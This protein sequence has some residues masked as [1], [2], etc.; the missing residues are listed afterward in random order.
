MGWDGEGVLAGRYRRLE[1]I[2]RGGMGSVWRAHDADLDREV[3]VKE[4]RVPEQVG[5]DE[6]AVWFARMEREARAAARL[7]HPGIVTVH[8]RVVGEDGRPWIVMELVQGRSLD[9]V[10]AD[11]GVLPARRVAA[12]GLAM[13]DA[14][15]AAHAQGIVHRD[16]KPANVLLEDERVVLTD[17]GIAAVEGDATLTRSGAVLGT[18][19]Y[20]SPEQVQGG[21][22]TPA[23]DLWSL[24]ATLYA[25]V[26]GR[27][28]FTAPTH[29]ALFVAIATR[30]PDPPGCGGPLGQVLTELLRKVPAERPSPARV[31]EL[32]GAVA[33]R[34]VP[35]VDAGP[36]RPA[37]RFDVPAD[38]TA[39]LDGDDHPVSVRGA[40]VCTWITVA[41]T[42]LLSWNNPSDDFLQG[43]AGY[44]SPVLIGLVIVLSAVVWR[45]THRPV[46]ALAAV[47]LINMGLTTSVLAAT[48]ERSEVDIS[49]E[50]AF[51][52]VA[53]AVALMFAF[54]GANETLLAGG[55]SGA[56]RR[57][58]RGGLLIVEGVVMTMWPWA[59]LG[60]LGIDINLT[61]A[62]IK[63]SYFAL[64]LAAVFLVWIAA[65]FVLRL[66]PRGI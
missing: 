47:A 24:G 55:P 1:L 14:L 53:G 61:N 36:S 9:R 17:F 65:Q 45:S 23:S 12:I 6:R 26:E 35:A 54:A 48:G 39:L 64:A 38:P 62:D 25:A 57:A 4:L 22:V 40:L 29:G 16:V 37:A 27:P 32:L 44:W 15:S 58:L 59:L 8:D 31:R 18:P 2:G 13:L 3:A 5:E 20:M 7:R 42:L 11:E 30:E 60:P 19:A 46:P 63:G 52:W 33:G 41:V 10:L 56:A 50:S 66:R 34:D 28:P 49:G 51:G 43:E 21:P